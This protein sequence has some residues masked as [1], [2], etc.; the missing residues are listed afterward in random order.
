MMVIEEYLAAQLDRNADL[1][2]LISR[3]WLRIE[4]GNVLLQ[5]AL[6]QLHAATEP[7]TSAARFISTWHRQHD[8]G[9]DA[10]G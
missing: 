5:S 1:E 9:W 4:R 7:N 2:A 8:R 6:L 3:L 10:I